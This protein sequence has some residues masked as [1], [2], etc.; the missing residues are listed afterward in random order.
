MGEKVEVKKIVINLV[1]FTIIASMITVTMIISKNI[2]S[3]E[4]PSNVME[5]DFESDVS[6]NQGNSTIINSEEKLDEENVTTSN[7]SNIVSDSLEENG[8]VDTEQRYI[9]NKLWI[10][11]YCT[12]SG[13]NL[14]CKSIRISGLKDKTI[15]KK[16]ND[17]IEKY[18]NEFK[19][20]VYERQKEEGESYHDYYVK[21]EV[22]ANF[23]NVLSILMSVCGYASYEY[24]GIKGL[25][26]DLTTGNELKIED[27]FLP[28]VDTD[29]YAE[30]KIYRWRMNRD[31]KEI[32][33]ETISFEGMTEDEI[34]SYVMDIHYRVDNFGEAKYIGYV[35]KYKN[36]EKEFVF[37][38]EQL[39]MYCK[40]K[41]VDYYDN[42]IDNYGVTIPYANHPE[43]VI[44]FN[45]FITE[46]SI[47]ET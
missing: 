16:I 3:T 18:E 5:N 13:E 41:I 45:K 30:E 22:K 10:S 39:E 46:D 23:S 37:T 33:K 44:I 24:L 31:S 25:N 29:M 15:E 20:L 34:M 38:P 9:E 4:L 11:D 17:D 19:N 26:Y 12:S 6:K 40:Y 28:S 36:S 2:L 21:G 14:V 35:K 47:F 42:G 1:V 7:D 43:E 32:P 8:Y 27:I